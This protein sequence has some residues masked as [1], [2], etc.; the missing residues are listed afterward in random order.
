MTNY[1]FTTFMDLS[2]DEKFFQTVENA[3]LPNPFPNI[4][5]R[6]GIESR[7]IVRES[8]SLVDLIRHAVDTVMTELDI[9]GRD[10][11]GV[12]ISSCNPANQESLDILARYIASENGINQHAGVNFA[13]S[14]FPASVEVAMEMENKRK[15]H[16]LLITA[17]IA[18]A[19][20][21]WDDENTAVVFADG[22]AATS[23]V[24][25]GKHPILHAGAKGDVKDK[26]YCLELVSKTGTMDIHGRY[27]AEP[28]PVISMGKHGGKQLYRAVPKRFLSLVEESEFGLEGVDIIAPHQANGKFAQKMRKELPGESSIKIVNTIADQGNI[29]SASIPVALSKSISSFKPGELVACPAKGAGKNFVSGTLSEGLLVFEVGE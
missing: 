18:S 12:V 22:L 11:E 14:G 9:K 6:T 1:G 2:K 21:D 28:R 10:C 29:V 8:T 23:I 16:I 25:G 20:V 5:E 7:Q 19:L 17:E 15:K 4:T 27:V 13:C 26:K 24:P 3:D